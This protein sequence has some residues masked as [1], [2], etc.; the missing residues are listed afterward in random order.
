[1][2]SLDSLRCAF[3]GSNTASR[4]AALALSLLL[5]PLPNL[6]AAEAGV[7]ADNTKVNKRDDNSQ[8][9]TPLDQSN[10]KADID[11]VAK[12]RS[13]L[14]DDNSLSVSAQNAKII[15]Q[16]GAVTLRGPVANATE[17]QRVDSIAKNIAGVRTVTNELDVKQ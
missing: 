12:I 8:A 4:A 9:L 15:V 5:A 16:N 10:A 1:M 11:I 7:D 13:A 14:T 6:Y 3:R 17:K 2:M